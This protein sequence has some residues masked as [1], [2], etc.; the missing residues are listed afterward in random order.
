MFEG[1][2]QTSW[3]AAGIIAVIG[4][5]TCGLLQPQRR[6]FRWLAIWIATPLAFSMLTSSFSSMRD[7]AGL[8]ILYLLIPTLPWAAASIAAYTSFR[9]MRR[10][11]QTRSR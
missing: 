11:I 6:S 10:A 7:A 1:I 5:A 3:M 2:S 8:L 4:G 9:L